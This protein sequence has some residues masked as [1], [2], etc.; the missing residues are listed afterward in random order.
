M[1]LERMKRLQDVF[2]MPPLASQVVDKEAV[3]VIEK[4]LASM[5]ER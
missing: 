2:N 5:A 1:I 3:A 4:W